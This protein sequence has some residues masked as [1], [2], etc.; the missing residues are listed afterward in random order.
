MDDLEWDPGADVLTTASSTYHSAEDSF[1]EDA[2]DAE[3]AAAPDDSMRAFERA[4]SFYST[5]S[6]E[7]MSPP[8]RTAATPPPLTSPQPT[9]VVQAQQQVQNLLQMVRRSVAMTS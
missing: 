1:D 9:N 6:A 8:P 2:E 3:D 5:G 7:P 4:D